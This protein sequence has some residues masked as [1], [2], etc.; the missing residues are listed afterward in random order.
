MEIDKTFEHLIIFPNPFS[1]TTHIKY[2]V[3][4][5]KQVKIEI[6]SLK[7][8]SIVTLIHESM[9]PYGEFVISFD[10]KQLPAGIY[11]CNFQ[12]DKKNISKK[13]V[14]FD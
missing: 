4:D 5:E 3:D 12:T 7:G 11:L 14:I 10:R 9:H 2:F 8:E 1:T 13:I 6:Y